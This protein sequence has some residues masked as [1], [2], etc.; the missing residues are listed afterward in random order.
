M[1]IVFTTLLFLATASISISQETV[2]DTRIVKNIGEKASTFQTE[3]PDYYDFLVYELN[4]AYFITSESPDPGVKQEIIEISR[5]KDESGN[6]FDESTLDDLTTFNFKA[7]N[8]KQTY[9][10]RVVYILAD[11]RYLVFYTLKEVKENYKKK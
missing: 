8:F 6:D 4:N 3:N 11:G 5:I 10:N 7:Y 2:P 1:K 9:D